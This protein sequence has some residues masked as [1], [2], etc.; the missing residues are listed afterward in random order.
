MTLPLFEHHRKRSAR[1]TD[2]HG[3]MLPLSFTSILEEAKAVRERAGLFDI[4]HMGHFCV[5][6]PGARKAMNSLIT[7]DLE[8]VPFGKSLYG[9]LLNPEG[10][11]IDDLILA[12]PD[13]ET[14]HMIVNAGN[15]FGDFFWIRSQL[16]SALTLTDMSPGQIALALQG[17]SARKIVGILGQGF[18]SMGRREVRLPDFGNG[19]LWVSR[20]GYTGEDGWEF[21][22]PAAILLD[23]YLKLSEGGPDFGMLQ[24]GLGARDLLRL[25]MAYPLYGQELGPDRTPIDAGL[26]FAVNFRKISF[27]GREPLLEKRSDSRRERLVGFILTDRGIPRSHCSVL[28]LDT[29]RRVGEVTSG[30]YS[31]RVGGGF[32]LAYLD[33][34]FAREFLLRREAGVE[35]HGKIHRAKVHARPFISGG[36]IEK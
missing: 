26:D 28:D 16:P 17:P 29:G 15:R 21:F 14:V 10:G 3:Y 22:G 25:E 19:S 9:L 2:F 8:M 6:G 34:S 35:I 36:L 1:M 12:C 18:E 24:A 13:E 7:S 27:V 31:P 23:Y 30:G 32:G 11:T 33:P 20:T 5:T 4:S